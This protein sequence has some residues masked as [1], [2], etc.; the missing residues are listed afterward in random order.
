M[1]KT[2]QSVG[3]KFL[4]LQSA[5]KQKVERKKKEVITGF[6]VQ[7]F[8]FFSPDVCLFR[9][10]FVCFLLKTLS[11]VFLFFVPGTVVDISAVCSFDNFDTKNSCH[12]CL[13]YL[14]MIIKI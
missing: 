4:N 2:P 5:V 14:I 9:L 13:I 6:L 8:L 7:S 12:P 11:V 1:L 10:W 3:V